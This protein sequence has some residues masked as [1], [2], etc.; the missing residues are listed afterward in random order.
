MPSLLRAARHRFGP[1]ILVAVVLAAIGSSLMLLQRRGRAPLNVIGRRTVLDALLVLSILL[2]LVVTLPPQP[3]LGGR[4]VSLV[5]F[6]D[7]WL[8]IRKVTVAD[9]DLLAVL[10]NLLLF[11][12]FGSVASIRW[13][14]LARLSR[15]AVVAA[16]FSILLEVVQYFM[17]GRSSSIDDVLLNTGGA[18][19]GALVARPRPK[20]PAEPGP[21]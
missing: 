12:P 20:W 19:L 21:G 6:R 13:P 2:I 17:G 11:A 5:P 18:V 1:L 4:R 8:A 16:L 10:G 9:T 15:M 14:S 7:T 3:G